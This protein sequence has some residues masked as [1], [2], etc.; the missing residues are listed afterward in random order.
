MPRGISILHGI[1]AH[2][3][4]AIV[5]VQ[6]RRVGDDGVWGDEDAQFGIVDS[7]GSSAVAGVEVETAVCKA[8]SK[9]E[10]SNAVGT[11][12]YGCPG[13]TDIYFFEYA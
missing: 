2:K 10:I 7:T 6:V 12:P 11:S 8:L 4:V 1:A 5:V 9:S 3:H 13:S